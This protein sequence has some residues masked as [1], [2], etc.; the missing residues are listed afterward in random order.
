M[1]SDRRRGM[2]HGMAQGKEK[3]LSSL[4]F[5][6]SSPAHPVENVSTLWDF[7]RNLKSKSARTTFSYPQSWGEIVEEV[8]RKIIISKILE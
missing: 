7:C 3:V 5:S 1:A 8:A 6:L 4:V 2:V